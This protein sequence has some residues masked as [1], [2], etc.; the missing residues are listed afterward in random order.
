MKLVPTLMLALVLLASTATHAESPYDVNGIK[1]GDREEAIK[2]TFPGI[3]CKPLEWKSDAA[4]RRCDDAK[5][6]INRV[7][8][9]ITFYL[10]ADAVQAIDVRFDLNYQETMVAYLKQRWGAPL[11]EGREKIVRKNQEER[12][13]Y[14]VRWEKGHDRALLSSLSSGG[15]VNLSISRGNFDEEI[16]RVK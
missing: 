9:R 5:I 1:L 14:K 2:K 10:K 4:D 6:A 12:E 7:E 15:R 13:S 16:Y 3:R 11:A 8:S